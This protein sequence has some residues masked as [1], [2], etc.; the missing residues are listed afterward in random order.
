MPV[1]LLSDITL[2]EHI[3]SIFHIIVKYALSYIIR[4][5]SSGSGFTLKHLS[6]FVEL[7]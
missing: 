1:N 2:K 6:M 4:I 5:G 3:C 7:T